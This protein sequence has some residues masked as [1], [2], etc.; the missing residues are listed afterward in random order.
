MLTDL[1]DGNLPS[2]YRMTLFAVGTKLPLVDVGMAIG[3]L[4]PHV[5]EHGLHVALRA[6]DTLVQS[7]QGIARLIVVEFRSI[8]NRFPSTQRVAVL[9]RNVKRTVGTTRSSTRLRR[10]R[11]GRGAQ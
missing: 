8:T 1:L 7:T 5:A 2:L 3:A 4:V 9:T 11:E 10:S 6:S